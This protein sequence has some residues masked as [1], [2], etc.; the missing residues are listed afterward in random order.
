MGTLIIQAVV[1][2]SF[3]AVGMVYWAWCELFN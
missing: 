3:I 1:I 2:S